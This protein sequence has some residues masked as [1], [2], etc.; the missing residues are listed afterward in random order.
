MS[1]CYDNLET[2]NGEFEY[3]DKKIIT[4]EVG[5]KESAPQ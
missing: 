1:V 2:S 5:V 4:F 3:F